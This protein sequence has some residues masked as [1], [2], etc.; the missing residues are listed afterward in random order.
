MRLLL[1]CI[2][3]AALALSSA[4]PRANAAGSDGS[5]AKK[6][7]D[8]SSNATSE[9]AAKADASAE[10]A[11]SS[12][13]SEIE[14]LRDLML[15]QAQQLQAQTE[16]L[17]QQQEKMQ[18]LE[19]QLKATGAPAA[20]VAASPAPQ[21]MAVSAIPESGHSEST[22]TGPC[23]RVCQHSDTIGGRA[24]AARSRSGATFAALFQYR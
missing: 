3:G 21:P 10:P 24:G 16:Q 20:N 19:E 18:K 22:D 5:P 4:T 2:L 11:K 6:A 14:E 17:K 12:L 13:E 23:F 9:S 15:T 1:G 7:A 8:S